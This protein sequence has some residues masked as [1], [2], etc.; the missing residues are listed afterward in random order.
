MKLTAQQITI[1]EEKIINYL[2]VKKPKNDKSTFLNGLGYTK[3]NYQSLIEDIKSLAVENEAT[4]SRTSEF[5]DLYS[6]KGKLKGRYVVTIWLE[7][8][9]DNTF[10]FVTLYPAQ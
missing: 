3:E 10:R 7:E 2:L 9:P 8:L 1:S 4:L 5:G 6:V